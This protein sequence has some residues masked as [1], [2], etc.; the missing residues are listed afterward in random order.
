MTWRDPWFCFQTWIEWFWLIFLACRQWAFF[1]LRRLASLLGED[2]VKSKLASKRPLFSLFSGMECVKHAWVFISAASIELWGI[3]PGICFGFSASALSVFNRCLN[4]NLKSNWLM[5]LKP[6]WRLTKD[7]RSWLWS[8]S[9]ITAFSVTYFRWLWT[10]RL[11]IGWWFLLKSSSSRKHIVS[12]M[13][14]IARVCFPKMQMPL[15]CLELHVCSFQR[16]SAS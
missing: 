16:S 8:G 4:S 9:K 12:G 15:E 1:V 7:A 14:R 5:D 11:K 10:T 2:T 13:K 6:R 3:K